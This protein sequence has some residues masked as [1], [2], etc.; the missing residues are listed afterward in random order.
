MSSSLNQQVIEIH[1][2]DLI[3]RLNNSPGFRELDNDTQRNPNLMRHSGQEM[4]LV[5]SGPL[6][7]FVMPFYLFI[8]FQLPLQER[9]ALGGAGALLRGAALGSAR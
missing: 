4:R 7:L 2:G 3:E 1:R 6:E 9:P 5:F 8:E